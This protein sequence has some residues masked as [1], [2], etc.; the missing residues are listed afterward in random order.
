[1]RRALSPR[2]ADSLCQASLCTAYYQGAQ[3]SRLCRT[4]AEPVC[5]INWIRRHNTFPSCRLRRKLRGPFSYVAGN[6]A[7]YTWRRSDKTV[8]GHAERGTPGAD[9]GI[10]ER[11]LLR[12]RCHN[13][14]QYVILYY[15]VGPTCR[16]PNGHVRAPLRYKREALAVH[17]RLSRHTQ[18]LANSL[19]A[20]QYNTQWT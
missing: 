18:A 12:L 2:H 6:A 19:E 3:C 1:M 16:G 13:Y 7:G 11:D 14:E 8:P 4:R 10:Q 5:C 9:N 17:N 20:R 15:I